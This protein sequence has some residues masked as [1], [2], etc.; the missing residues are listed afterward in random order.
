MDPFEAASPPLRQHGAV[1]VQRPCGTVIILG[2]FGGP[3][4]LWC[5]MQV[6]I[7]LR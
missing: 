5:R 2:A 4:F 3:L 6:N 1:Q 7:I